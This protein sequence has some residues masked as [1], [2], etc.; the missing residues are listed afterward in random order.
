MFV[1]KENNEELEIIKEDEFKKK[2]LNTVEITKENK[3]ILELSINSMVGLSNLGTMKVKG[4]IQAREVVVLIDYGL[5]TH[6]FICER[7]VIYLQLA[8]RDTSNYGVILRSGTTIKGKGVCK[9]VELVL[10]EWKVTKNSYHWNW[11]K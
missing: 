6:N 10:N 1:V 5:A 8:K 7:I 2:E 9:A 4:K 11:G 3:T